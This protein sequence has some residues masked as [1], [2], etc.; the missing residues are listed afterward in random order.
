[1]RVV[2][3]QASF[4]ESFERAV[5]EAK[6]AFGD[7]TVFIERESQSPTGVKDMAHG[8]GVRLTRQDSLITLDISRYN[9][10][11]TDKATV[12]TSLSEIVPSSDVTKRQVSCVQIKCHQLTL[13]R[14]SRSRQHLI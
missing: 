12:S 9:C 1:M 2:R 5:S 11:P 3:D 8:E 4:K 13:Y 10:W 7:V 6:S 14:L